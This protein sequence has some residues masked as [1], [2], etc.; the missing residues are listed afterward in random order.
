MKISH[1]HFAQGTL[2][3]ENGVISTIHSYSK[4]IIYLDVLGSE[5]CHFH[6]FNIIILQP[7]TCNLVHISLKR[8][9]FTLFY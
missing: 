9:Y 2:S 7:F 4:V 5:K 1:V 6:G 8:L 3:T